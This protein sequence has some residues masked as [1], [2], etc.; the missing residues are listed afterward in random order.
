MG[1]LIFKGECD[2]K[3]SEDWIRKTEKIFEAIRCPEEEKVVLATYTLQEKAD[4]WW[5]SEKRDIFRSRKDISWEE[6]LIVFRQ[7]FFP[8][9][10]QDKKEQEFLDLKQ[11]SLSVI[12][13]EARFAEMEK[14]APHICTDDKRRIRRFVRGLKPYIRNRIVAQD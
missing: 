4:I 14:F 13:Y 3:V 9:Y 12:E 5:I 10:I 2:P 6:F 7:K 8:E 1:P 11:G